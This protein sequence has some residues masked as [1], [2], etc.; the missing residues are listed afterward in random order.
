MDFFSGTASFLTES[1]MI[2]FTLDILEAELWTWVFWIARSTVR[3][4][5]PWEE[6]VTGLE[7]LDMEEG[8]GPELGLP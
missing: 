5:K 2:E 7:L 3:F 6:M 4:M 1:S 8:L